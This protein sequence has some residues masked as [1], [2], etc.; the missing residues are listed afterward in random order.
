MKIDLEKDVTGDKEVATAGLIFLS[1]SS[2]VL[3]PR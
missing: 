2:Q 1:R 3:R